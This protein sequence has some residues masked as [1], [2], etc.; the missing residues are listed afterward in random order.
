MSSFE[1][2][3]FHAEFNAASV[4]AYLLM[5]KISWKLKNVKLIMISFNEIE[6]STLFSFDRS[7][8][9]ESVFVRDS[10]TRNS[11]SPFYFIDDANIYS[12]SPE[13]RCAYA[14]RAD[15]DWLHSPMT[16]AAVRSHIPRHCS[17]VSKR[18][19]IVLVNK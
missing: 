16:L 10:S 3:K 7:C 11:H 18:A 8:L 2:I 15:A 14:V 5:Q 4:A 6:L 1:L 17:T 12:H 13:V 9:P 19:V